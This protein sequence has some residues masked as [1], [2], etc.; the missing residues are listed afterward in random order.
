MKSNDVLTFLVTEREIPLDGVNSRRLADHFQQFL[1]FQVG[2]L[3]VLYNV[4][5]RTLW[6]ILR[7][8]IATYFFNV[9]LKKSCDQ[10]SFFKI[11]G[12]VLKTHF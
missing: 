11:A 2:C 3:P 4:W 10:F 9:N 5:Q 7:Q 12:E 8:A 1:Y 6:P